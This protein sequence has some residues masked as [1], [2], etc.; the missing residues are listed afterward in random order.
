MKIFKNISSEHFLTFT[1]YVPEFDMKVE[2]STDRR[3]MAVTRH[4]QVSACLFSRHLQTEVKYGGR[5]PKFTWAPCH[6]MCTDVVVL[7]G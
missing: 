3:W 1:V 2:A 7:I 6:V 4:T 5:S